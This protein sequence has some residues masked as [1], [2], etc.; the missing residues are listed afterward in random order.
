[1]LRVVET[2]FLD[3][4]PVLLLSSLARPAP[5]LDC[6]IQRL[7]EDRVRVA[8][9][10]RRSHSLEA[11]TRRNNLSRRVWRL[12]R[13]NF[14]H[15][16]AGDPL[17]AQWRRAHRLP[18]AGRGSSLTWSGFPASPPMWR[19]SGKNLRPARYL[20]RVGSL[21][22]LIRFDKRGT[23]M[24]DHVGDSPT[25]ETRMDDIRAV[26]DAAES[27]RAVLIGNYDGGALGA[28]FAATYP[29]RTAGLVCGTPCRASRAA[30]NFHGSRRGRSTSYAVR[31]SSAIGATASGLQTSGLGH[32]CPARPGRSL[33]RGP[34][35]SVS[36]AA[37]A[38]WQP[39]GART[40]ISMCAVCFR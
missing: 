29:E 18:G 28:L 27:E 9:R 23:G 36:A 16:A 5:R 33:W 30:Q 34:G 15:G 24:L 1:M 19:S 8:L 7:L 3:D 37:L 21:G 4:D 31:R 39:S 38:R 25:L 40:Q 11:E 17:H 13:G 32:C 12:G 6:R 20:R 22:R 26:M 35:T 14:C 2:R 10:G